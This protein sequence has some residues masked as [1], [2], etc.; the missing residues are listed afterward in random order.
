MSRRHIGLVVSTIAVIVLAASAP[1]HAQCANDQARKPT[2]SRAQCNALQSKVHTQT[3]CNAPRSCR[4][5][6]DQDELQKRLKYNQ[7]C[8]AAREA[9]EECYLAP[10]SGHLT[11]IS[12]VDKAIA[13][14]QNKLQ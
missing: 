6:S 12:D 1:V 5:V 8:K 11:A 2:C 9:V 7:D 10:N 4:N 3:T 13:T 14:C